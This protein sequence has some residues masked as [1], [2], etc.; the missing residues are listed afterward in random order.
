MVF[1]CWKYKTR[2]KEVKEH[3]SKRRDT[4]RPHFGRPN[5]VKLLILSKLKHGL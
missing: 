1:V 4:P 2:M 3:V 5:M